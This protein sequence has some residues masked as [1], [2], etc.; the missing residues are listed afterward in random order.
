MSE[1]FDNESVLEL[2]RGGD[3][4]AFKQVFKP[5]ESYAV[6]LS[7]RFFAPGFEHEDLYQ[8]ALAGFASALL[9]FESGGRLS[10]AEF[11]K[12]SMRNTVVASVRRA[13]R[14]KRHNTVSTEAELIEVAAEQSCRPDLL[15]EL[16]SEC[17]EVL[18]SLRAT[19]S[20]LEWTV[21]TEILVGASL[22]EVAVRHQLDQRAAENALSRARAKARRMRDAA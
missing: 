2:A 17:A 7:R 20:P 8:E 13:T 19:L 21:L 3:C 6:F 11:A 18:R 10:F 22:E 12:L 14:L 4:Q 16:R 5:L 1:F 15:V 9:G